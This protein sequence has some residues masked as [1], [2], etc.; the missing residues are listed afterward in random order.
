MTDTIVAQDT[1]VGSAGT[2][3]GRTIPMLV[4]T[5]GVYTTPSHMSLTGSGGAVRNTAAGFVQADGGTLNNALGVFVEWVYKIGSYAGTGPQTFYA[6][7]GLPTIPNP[8]WQLF[9]PNGNGGGGH[10]NHLLVGNTNV[11]GTY[12][13][14]GINPYTTVGAVLTLR[15]EIN[16]YAQT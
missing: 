9:G 10:I 6:N 1:F 8:F 12:V 15:S 13:D 2:L 5:T 11:A 4:G 16:P 3:D 7:S 14:L